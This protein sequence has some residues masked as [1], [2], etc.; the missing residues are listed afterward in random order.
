MTNE[1]L[2]QLL[3]EAADCITERGMCEH[4]LAFLQTP[5][6]DV[7]PNQFDPL[8]RRLRIAAETFSPEEEAA[9]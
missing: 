7:D 6:F 9:E 4:A 8:V 5:R 3:R 1:E 2:A